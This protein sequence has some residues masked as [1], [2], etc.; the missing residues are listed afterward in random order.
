MRGVALVAVSFGAMFGLTACAAGVAA[1]QSTLVDEMA[2]HHGGVCPG[3]LPTGEDPDGYGFG[4]HE[5]ARR[6]PSL[7]A[8]ESAWVCRYNPV[9]EGSGPHGAGSRFLWRL[10]GAP[11]PVA[12]ERLTAFASSLSELEPQ[13]NDACTADLGPRWMLV[14]SHARDLTGVV[15]D[16]YGCHTVR[17]TDDP[18]TRAPGDPGQVGTVSG[19]LSGPAHLLEDLK[20]A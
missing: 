3:Q 18:F 11:K 9:P 2:L 5:A 8:P 6:K 20:S 14:Y 17:L 12:P 7:L 1:P 4:T 19:Q 15:V 16:D 13:G 10:D